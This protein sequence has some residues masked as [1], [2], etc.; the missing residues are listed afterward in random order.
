MADSVIF[1][2]SLES[3]F[4]QTGWKF[5]GAPEQGK[6]TRFSTIDRDKTDRAG[7]L[8][9]LPDGTG[10]TFGC[11]R[12]GM[13]YCWQKREGDKPEP[14]PEERARALQSATATRRQV[15][16]EREA[17]YVRTA[18]QCAAIWN[19]LDSAPA[20]HSYLQ[21]K[22]IL[23][24]TARM[25]STGRLVLPIYDETGSIQSLQTIAPDG[26]KRFHSGGKTTGGRVF[27]GNPTDG[28]TIVLTEGFATGAS[29]HEATK[30][31]VAVCFSGSNLRHVATSI[32]RQYPKS[33]L[34]IAGDLDHHG[35]GQKYAEEAAEVSQ[36]THI[37][38]PAFK[39]GRTTGDF[40]DLH[41]VESSEAVRKQLKTCAVA[42]PPRPSTFAA[43]SLPTADARDGTASTRPLTEL[44]NAW[45][46]FDTY[47]GR[48]KYVHNAQ[49]WIFW[50]DTAWRWDTGAGVRTL[51]AT[52]PDAIYAEGTRFIKDA[53]HFG[54]W[55]RKSQEKRTIDA[56]ISLLS[57]MASIRVPL[58]LIDASPLVAGLRQAQQV[59][60]LST[61][62]T[63]AAKPNDYVTKTLGVDSVG[64]AT[65]AVRWIQFLEQ[66]FNGD[67]ELIDWIQRF[68]GYLL[69]GSTEEQFFL[70]CFGHG[71]NGKSVFIEVLKHIMGDYSRALASETLSESRRQAGSATPDLAALI[72]ARLAICSETEDNTAMAE[73]LIKSLVS[74]DSMSV[75]QLYAAPV[76][77]K[78][79]FKL[80]MAGNHKPIVRGNDHGIW[81]RVRLVPFNRTFSP[82]ERDP[83]LLAT[84]KDE[85]AHIVA[86]MLQGCAAWQQ[87]G[88]AD[89]PKAVSEATDD[90]REDQDLTG[91]WLE[92][93]TT[94]SNH[95]ETASSAL[96]EDY[97]QWSLDNGLKPA[98][99][100][101][102]GRR[103]AERGFEPIKATAGK[104][105]WRGL[106]L[107]EP[108][109]EHSYAT[110][111]GGF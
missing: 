18:S 38:L 47:N 106:M 19:Y 9:L 33:I 108:L 72:G 92:E 4:N 54:R 66:I 107:A 89:T 32:R 98:S 11:W 63:R 28:A 103:L 35:A 101:S 40:N 79:H 88:L 2:P 64:D 60:D 100:V 15:E 105:V 37:V 52:L 36:P 93:R 69:T 102:L 83:H 81:R 71:A 78:P 16:Q 58:A 104:R 53:Q 27:L 5:P 8:M 42:N 94:R 86:W 110:A 14:T 10:A 46:L 82:S 17:R 51:A 31:P 21:R 97:K 57:D 6:V 65:K 43:P 29:I 22:S 24:H 80:V 84:L 44:G 96:Y 111:K 55:S 49:A 26:S 73:V 59:I 30:I 77:F 20:I 1:S 34:L 12:Q 68:C 87:Q 45:R 76:E 50:D 109:R 39:D 67:G 48:V 13:S 74:G 56:S 62:C 75:R 3:A 95:S 61:G 70:F 23:P 7:W 90:Y 25:D 41:A 99:N 85:G 91:R